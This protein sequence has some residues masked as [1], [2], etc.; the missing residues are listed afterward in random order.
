[1]PPAMRSVWWAFLQLHGARPSGGMGPSAIPPS[2]I[3]AWQQLN[4]V[5]LTPFEVDTLLA[6]D[7]VALRAMAP[8]TPTDKKK[9]A[10]KE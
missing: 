6:L 8:P 10:G 9:K 7:A 2:E 3:L 5:E 1:M 4:G